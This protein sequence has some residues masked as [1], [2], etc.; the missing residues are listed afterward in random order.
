MAITTVEPQHSQYLVAIS[1]HGCTDAR[2]T[3]YNCIL[4]W[5]ESR[6]YIVG[7]PL[8]AM[9]NHNYATP[10]ECTYAHKLDSMTLSHE[11]AGNG[12]GMA[13]AL[14]SGCWGKH[15]SGSSASMA[16]ALLLL[17]GH[18]SLGEHGS[19]SS[20]EHGSCSSGEHGS[21]SPDTPGTQFCPCS[22]IDSRLFSKPQIYKTLHL[23]CTCSIQRNLQQLIII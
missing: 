10:Q 9:G 14:C 16:L 12:Q 19:G 6:Q 13:L 20:G 21:G 3:K 2:H 7:T 4:M 11:H 17:F 22:T 23:D 5:P 8:R 1:F 15:W 18:G